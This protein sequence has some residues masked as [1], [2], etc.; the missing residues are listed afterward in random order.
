MENHDQINGFTG[1]VRQLGYEFQDARRSIQYTAREELRSHEQALLEA[2]GKHHDVRRAA[3]QMAERVAQ[4][5]V[6]QR[7]LVEIEEALRIETGRKQTAERAWSLERQR[8]EEIAAAQLAQEAA[9]QQRR[10]N[11]AAQAALNASR[12][13]P[14]PA[15]EPIRQVSPPMT[16]ATATQVANASKTES[17]RP[18]ASSTTIPFLP[19]VQNIVNEATPALRSSTMTYLG[20]SLPAS[21]PLEMQH[22]YLEYIKILNSLKE[23]RKTFRDH[24]LPDPRFKQVKP[25][26]GDD[27]RFIKKSVGQLTEDRK[28][29]REIMDRVMEKISASVNSPFPKV[30]LSQFLLGPSNE[31]QEVSSYYIYLMNIFTK[32]V[33]SQFLVDATADTRKADAIGLFAS[34]LLA[35]SQVQW[36][37][38]ISFWPFLLAKFARRC[39]VL[40][41]VYGD[42]ATTEGRTLLGWGK[43]DGTFVNN[44]RHAE[45]MTGLA[46]GWASIT[47]R[48]Y[49]KSRLENPVPSW[50]FWRSAA[51]IL[52]VP[53][54]EVTNTHYIVLK[55]LIEHN[56]A[57]IIKLFGN[58]GTMILQQAVTAYPDNVHTGSKVSAQALKLLGDIWEKDL[59]FRVI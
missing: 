27:R 20:L 4:D 56:E 14:Q 45:R 36:R 41:G 42:E 19:P 50:Y 57:R 31:A 10:E 47:L 32:A 48:D 21:L 9:D 52:N 30:S 23:L 29:N 39:P 5:L 59:H 3:E 38:Q 53:K 35:T 46:A 17:A 26:V 58:Y 49:N 13:V 22:Q 37:N 8:Q 43:A 12:Q 2:L 44:Q 24:I 33:F 55:A 25:Q 40:F 16:F 34:Q 15:P 1:P 51:S 6:R 54:N 7:Q 28:K 11:I 18:I